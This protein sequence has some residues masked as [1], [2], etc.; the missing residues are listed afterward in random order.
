MI[1]ASNPNSYPGTGSVITDVINGHS[2]TMTGAYSFDDGALTGGI[3]ATLPLIRAFT[4]P[5]TRS[6]QPSPPAR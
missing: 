5:V 6:I 3:K 4:A 1:D 2:L